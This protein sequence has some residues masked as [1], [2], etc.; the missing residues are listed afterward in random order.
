MVEIYEVKGLDDKEGL[1]LFFQCVFGEFKFEDGY[2]K[3]LE[4]IVNYVNGNVKVL[5]NYGNELKG[6]KL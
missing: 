6:K 4:M 1:K 2:L 3:V 5:S